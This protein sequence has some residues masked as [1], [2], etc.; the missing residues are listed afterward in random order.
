MRWSFLKKDVSKPTI[1]QIIKLNFFTDVFSENGSFEQK[2]RKNVFLENC[3]W[4][5]M[6]K[7]CSE[8]FRDF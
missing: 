5:N 8:D 1:K 2:M 6:K 4:S 3:S 7:G